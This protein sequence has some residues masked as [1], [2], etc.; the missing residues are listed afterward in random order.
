M[1]FRVF[2]MSSCCSSALWPRPPALA[3]P[4][5][6]S[7]A[8]VALLFDALRASVCSLSEAV[9][10]A[11]SRLGPVTAALR[12]SPPLSAALRRSPETCRSSKHTGIIA[13]ACSADKCTE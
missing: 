12:R 5:S 9:S 11:R 8:P 4:S 2:L 6:S 13:P 7:P 10:V 3:P 1:Q